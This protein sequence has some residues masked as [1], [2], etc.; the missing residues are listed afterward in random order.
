MKCARIPSFV[1]VF[2]N[3]FDLNDKLL[4]FVRTLPSFSN[5]KLLVFGDVVIVWLCFSLG[6]E[7]RPIIHSAIAIFHFNNTLE[8][9]SHFF[10]KSTAPGVGWPG[11]HAVGEAAREWG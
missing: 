5:C 8:V 10:F 2:M 3:K 11:S 1:L 9:G 6:N 7:S 4:I